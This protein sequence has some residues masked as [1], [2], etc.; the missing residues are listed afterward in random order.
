MNEAAFE[1]MYRK[2]YGRV[3]AYALRRTG[4]SSAEDVA[5]ETFLVAWRRRDELVGDPLPWLL[6]VARRVLANQLRTS[7]RSDATIV[8]AGLR[9]EQAEGRTDEGPDVLDA[10]MAAALK[11]LRTQDREAL[12]L[13]AWEDLSPGQA[14][15]IVGCSAA[16]FRVRLHRAKRRLAQE[17]AKVESAQSADVAGR[18]AVATGSKG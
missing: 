16:T 7:T 14:S 8:R 15:R 18:P 10:P 9:T 6:G 4:R 11:S 12:M 17:L 2:D 13:S 3:L 5:A 1:A